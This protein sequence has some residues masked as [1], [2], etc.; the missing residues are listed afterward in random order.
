MNSEAETCSSTDGPGTDEMRPADAAGQNGFTIIEVMI[1][2][3]IFSI[4]ILAAWALQHSSTRGNTHA[5]HLTLAASAATDRLEQLS[6][7]PYAH[8]DLA[9]G[10]H[11]P[12]QNLDGIDNNFDGVIDEAG[13]SGPLGITWLVAD[14]VPIQRTKTIRVDV[15]MRQRTVSVTSYR[16]DL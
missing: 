3:A 8:A 6:L 5:R 2:I 1:A 4:G 16:A 10:A 14:D 12:V 13:E 11:A 7:L 9:A 15:S